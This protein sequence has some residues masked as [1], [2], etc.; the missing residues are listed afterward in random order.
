MILYHFR[1]PAIT[2]FHGRD[3]QAEKFKLHTHS[4]AELYCILA[5]RGTFH[6]EGSHY[7]LHPGDI[8]LMRPAEAHY[9]EVDPTVPYERICINFNIN[10][11]ASLDPQGLLLTPY[12]NRASGVYNH[13]SASAVTQQLLQRII[14]ADGNLAITCAHLILLLH[15]L[16]VE[17]GQ[18]PHL[19]QAESS[20]EYQIIGYIN[21]NLDQDL[22]IQK[23]CDCFFLSRAQLCRRFQAATGTSVGKYVSAKRLIQA[24]Q[25][26][27]QGQKPTEIYTACGYCDYATFYRAYKAYFGHSP[28]NTA[29]ALSYE[30]DGAEFS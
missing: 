29:N 16:R 22:T 8:M 25:L 20:V 1:D 7:D 26:I 23:L 6:V 9:V 28:R 27:L 4:F 10:L 21:R 24:Q 12:F 2:V 5:G 18:K 17:F 19:E 13:Y 11:F 3:E 15:N 30:A 14:R